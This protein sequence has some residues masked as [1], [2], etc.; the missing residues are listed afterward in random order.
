MENQYGRY[1]APSNEVV[2]GAEK[3]Y[4]V[5]ENI[6]EVKL[7]LSLTNKKLDEAYDEY[8]NLT[9]LVD[10]DFWQGDA[11]AGFKE[12][13]EIL[14]KYHFELKGA[15]KKKEDA[16]DTLINS[17]EEFHSTNSIIKIWEG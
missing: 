8:L 1:G 17:T 10:D 4:R 12:L 2:S 6:N 14:G 5:N 16:I 3:L 9:K 11:K 15:I 7:K 13:V